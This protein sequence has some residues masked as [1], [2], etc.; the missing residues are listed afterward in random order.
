MAQLMSL[1][2]MVFRFILWHLLETPC[3]VMKLMNSETH[4]WNAPLASLGIIPFAGIAF[5]IIL[6]TF[7][8][9]RNRSRSLL[10]W[11][12]LFGLGFTAGLETLDL[13]L[14]S[15]HENHLPF[16]VVRSEFSYGRKKIIIMYFYFF[17]VY[18]WRGISCRGRGVARR[19]LG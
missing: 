16:S 8:M 13:H 6:P 4:S 12:W 17:W 15:F 11:R 10:G 19:K 18:S 9:G 7:T 1:P 14:A 3:P 2:L 5:F